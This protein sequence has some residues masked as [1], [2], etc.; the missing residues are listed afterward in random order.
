LKLAFP[1]SE[2]YLETIAKEIAQEQKQKDINTLK[3]KIANGETEDADALSKKLKTQEE[4]DSDNDTFF[5]A[6][7]E[8]THVST[9]PAETSEQEEKPVGPIDTGY[10]KL[11]DFRNK[12]YLAPLTTVCIFFY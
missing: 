8:F 11:I 9:A 1:R 12:T 10:R 5:D 3:R 7:S 2:A 4:E 6:P